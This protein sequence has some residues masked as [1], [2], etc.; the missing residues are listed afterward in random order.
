MNNHRLV[1]PLLVF[2]LGVAGC[3]DRM[4]AAP[5]FLPLPTP[6]TPLKPD[7]SASEWDVRRAAYDASFR[8]VVCYYGE[9]QDQ[10]GQCLPN[11]SVQ[12]T[13]ERLI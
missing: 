4:V 1:I 10:F 12:V 5:G 9:V 11:T 7:D 6:V 3:E 13:I 8:G 2:A